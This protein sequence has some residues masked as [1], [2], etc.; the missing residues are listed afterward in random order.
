MFTHYF[1]DTHFFIQETQVSSVTR[2]LSLIT[3][4]TWVSLK[5][6]LAILVTTKTFLKTRLS[7]FMDILSHISSNIV[8]KTFLNFIRA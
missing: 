4:L 7:C 3:L 2:L 8:T 5:K 6:L 1:N